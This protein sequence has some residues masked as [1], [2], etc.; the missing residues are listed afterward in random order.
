MG[1]WDIRPYMSTHGGVN[2]TS[3]APMTAGQGFLPGEPIVIVDAGTVSTGPKDGTELVLA[4][5]DG[6][7][8]GLAINGPGA[9]ATAELTAAYGWGRLYNHPDSGDTYA[10]TSFLG[11]LGSPRIWFIPFGDPNQ[12]FI[13]S[14]VVAAAGGGAGA[15]LTGADRGEAF[16]MTY[17]SGTTP[18]LG[19]GLERTGATK[20]TDVYCSVVDILDAFGNPV[21]IGGTGVY[22]VFQALL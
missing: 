6:G 19:W 2:R 1:L 11:T 5:A 21:S 17:V 4:D 22:A 8:I 7:Q 18:D 3:W 10:N 12:L 20:G 14:N 13:C 16:Q 15:A 9:A